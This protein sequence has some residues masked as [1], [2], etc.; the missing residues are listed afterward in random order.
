MQLV[1]AT[2]SGAAGVFRIDKLRRPTITGRVSMFDN[3]HGAGMRKE[4]LSLSAQVDENNP[5]WL[6][7]ELQAKNETA[8]VGSSVP[9]SSEKRNLQ[10]DLSIFTDRSSSQLPMSAGLPGCRYPSL[11]RSTVC[12]FIHSSRRAANGFRPI[13]YPIPRALSLNLQL[14]E[15]WDV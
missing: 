12:N 9:L 4:I 5:S 10:D 11:E 1:R 8:P 3:F 6:Y 15:C 7:P 13:P 2:E 14:T